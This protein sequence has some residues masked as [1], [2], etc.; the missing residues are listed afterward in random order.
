ML[1]K[2]KNTISPR[3]RPHSPICLNTWSH[4][5]LLAAHKSSASL[6]R[7]YRVRIA[8]YKQQFMIYD[9]LVVI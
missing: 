4:Y 8:S 1:L 7:N 9:V 5:S 2:K 3:V 6:V